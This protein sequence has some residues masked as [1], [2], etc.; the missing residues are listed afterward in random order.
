MVYARYT[1]FGQKSQK[2]ELQYGYWSGNW[3]SVLL[4]P[5]SSQFVRSQYQPGKCHQIRLLNKPLV[6]FMATVGVNKFTMARQSLWMKALEKRVGES[7]SSGLRCQ[8]LTKP[9]R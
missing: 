7:T 1:I 8:R 9:Y 6:C 5:S 4:A 3:V 2:S